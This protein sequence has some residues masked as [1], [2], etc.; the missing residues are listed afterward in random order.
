MCYKIWNF[1]RFEAI[2]TQKS[3]DH[4]SYRTWFH[5]PFSTFI[6]HV[7]WSPHSNKDGD[8]IA[9]IF[10][11][12]WWLLTQHLA[13]QNTSYRWMCMFMLRY[14]LCTTTNVFEWN[15]LKW[16]V[17]HTMAPETDIYYVDKWLHTTEYCGMMLGPL[18]WI[19]S[20]DGKVWI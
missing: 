14:T 2:I 13:L 12:W 17:Y 15:I 8:R 7:L 9:M 3:H 5:F 19:P 1:G 11:T 6:A 16:R 4:A 20:S 10:I 18:P